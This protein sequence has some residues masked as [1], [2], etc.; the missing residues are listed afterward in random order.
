MLRSLGIPARE[1]VGYVPGGYNPITDLYQ[2]HANDAHAWVQ[3]WFPGYGWQDFDPTA[4]V[5]ASRAQPRG[6]RVARRRLRPRPPPPVPVAAVV[7]ATGLVVVCVRWRRAR[8]TTG[9]TVARRAGA[10]RATGRPPPPALRDPRRV[11]RPARRARGPRRY[12]E[13]VGLVGGGRAY[14]G[15]DPPAHAARPR[16]GGQAGQGSA[17]PRH[18]SGRRAPQTVRESL[19]DATLVSS[20]G[21]PF[22]FRRVAVHPGGRS[23]SRRTLRRPSRSVADS[24][25]SSPPR[26]SVERSSGSGPP[27]TSV[28]R[29][30]GSGPPK[31]GRS[32][33]ATSFVEWARSLALTCG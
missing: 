25:G 26:R 18:R 6:H 13:P 17:P 1:A 3:V 24:S 12:L 22:L 29:S 11:R 32:P 16:L 9:R 27:I 8:P 31:I 33:S 20:P 21:D 28:A 5:P 15:P 14:G 10:G 2:V 30:S 19:K 4:V 7:A 23:P